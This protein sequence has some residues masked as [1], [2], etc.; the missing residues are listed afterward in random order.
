[1]AQPTEHA[2]LFLA[3]VVLGCGLCAHP[4][5]LT[6]PPEPVPLAFAVAVA[7]GWQG[8]LE[9]AGEHASPRDMEAAEEQALLRAAAT[10]AVA[11]LHRCARPAPRWQGLCQVPD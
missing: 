3:T 7:Q 8:A 1:M 6:G 5:A 4:S 2:C 11:V 9:D 10:A